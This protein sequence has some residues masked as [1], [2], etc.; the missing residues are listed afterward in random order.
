MVG[1]KL[2]GGEEKRRVDVADEEKKD[3]K[4][5]EWKRRLAEK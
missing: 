1:N 2:R 5:K 4:D 3:N